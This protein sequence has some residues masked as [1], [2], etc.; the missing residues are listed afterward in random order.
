MPGTVAEVLHL[1]TRLLLGWIEEVA[2]RW[3]PR[4]SAGSTRRGAGAVG[5]GLALLLLAGGRGGSRR[6]GSPPCSS[7]PPLLL[8]VL[9]A[10]APPPLAGALRPGVVRWHGG[11]ADV[12]VLGGGGWRSR[13]GPA[14]VLEALRT[15]GVGAVD[16]IVVVDAEV[17]ASL[18]GAVTARHPT[19]AV[20]VPGAVDPGER[21]AGALA[22]PPAGTALRVG[23]LD[24]R[25]TPG[26]DRLVVEAWPA[27]G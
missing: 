2:A 12:V 16:L 3:P 19:A 27:P 21:P 14:E 4:R 17:D 8:A 18:V 6:A 5:G 7:A 23:D 26:E 11:E 9:A 10:H 20:L 1:P 24:V 25:I 22:V 13:L 15:A